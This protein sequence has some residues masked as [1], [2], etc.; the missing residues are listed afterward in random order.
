MQIFSQLPNQQ[1]DV[2]QFIIL[3][4]GYRLNM[5]QLVIS[6]FGLHRELKKHEEAS[7]P[8]GAPIMKES[9]MKLRVAAQEQ[10]SKEEKKRLSFRLGRNRQEQQNKF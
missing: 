6:R 7:P 5:E 1:M 10:V 4:M 8:A 2:H 9:F 3:M